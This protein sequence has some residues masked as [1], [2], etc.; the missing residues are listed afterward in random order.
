MAIARS[1]LPQPVTELKFPDFAKVFAPAVEKRVAIPLPLSAGVKIRILVA[2]GDPVS[3]L[4]LFHFLAQA[5]Y[6]VVIAENG[7]ETI[8]ELRKADHPSI[9]ILD[10][11]M[12][13]MSAAEICRR[14]RAIEKP[15]YLILCGK[16]TEMAACAD[17]GADTMLPKPIV[18]AELLS[19]VKSGLHLLEKRRGQDA[20]VAAGADWDLKLP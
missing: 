2:D 9:A 10:C 20:R 6:D 7:D 18:E 3:R 19:L 11:T 4:F 17:A 1:S 5:D 8:A 13:G 15:V 14:M 16:S 12:P